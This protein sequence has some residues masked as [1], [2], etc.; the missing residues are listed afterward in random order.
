MTPKAV[1]DLKKIPKLSNYF[2]NIGP[3]INLPQNIFKMEQYL[4]FTD[5]FYKL[6]KGDSKV[7]PKNV[8]NS[9]GKDGD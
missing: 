6:I 8:D 7:C 9:I 2:F 1:V 4:T 5:F 3:Y